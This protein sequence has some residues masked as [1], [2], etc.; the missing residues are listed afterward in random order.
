ME[1]SSNQSLIR[2]LTILGS[3]VI[4]AFV[5]LTIWG[6]DNNAVQSVVAPIITIVTLLVS[7]LLTLKVSSEA[8]TAALESKAVSELN[9]SGIAEVH[10]LVNGQKTA[11]E[12]QIADLRDRLD[13]VHSTLAVERDRS[14]TALQT[15]PLLGAPVVGVPTVEA[16]VVVVAPKQP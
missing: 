11:L 10:G 1:S 15:A 12:K 2:S 7:G 16:P 3:V 8:K 4:M 6:P 13:K 9:A 14:T 5:A